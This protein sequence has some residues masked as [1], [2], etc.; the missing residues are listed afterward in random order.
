MGKKSKRRGGDKPKE[1]SARHLANKIVADLGLTGEEAAFFQDFVTYNPP[2]QIFEKHKILVTKRLEVATHI[3]VSNEYRFAF[4]HLFVR[5]TAAAERIRA[6]P[7]RDSVIRDDALSN[8]ARLKLIT[9][10]NRVS[11]EFIT[12]PMTD[13]SIGMAKHAHLTTIMFWCKIATLTCCLPLDHSKS[14]GYA[15]LFDND[16]A[17]L[18]R[19]ISSNHN[20]SMPSRTMAMVARASIM[21]QSGNRTNEA[22][23]RR[24]A[25]SLFAQIVDT[26]YPLVSGA[27][28]SDGNRFEDAASATSF[29]FYTS[30]LTDIMRMSN[31][32]LATLEGPS[33]SIVPLKPSAEHISF[34]SNYVS[35]T[36]GAFCDH[37][38]KSRED[39]SVVNFLKCASCCLAH[40]CND[41]CQRKAWDNGHNEKCTKFGCF[42]V[43]NSVMIERGI[44]GRCHAYVVGKMEDGNFLKCE[45]GGGKFEVVNKSDLRHTR[46][47]L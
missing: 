45:V 6:L 35:T 29:S 21:Y 7:L 14:F 5:V 47:L 1:D 38:H 31:R 15:A 17:R 8:E 43:G 39:A 19:S 22:S 30:L 46:P 26:D 4:D 36:G 24:R 32:R 28:E 37:C 3:G 12:C 27:D 44:Y 40:Y 34:L 42:G 23:H 11:N 33:R 2:D 9:L 13:N 16:A 20:E 18:L 25:K 10:L 41:D